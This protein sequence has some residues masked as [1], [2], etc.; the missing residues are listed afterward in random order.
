VDRPARP[1]R[2]AKIGLDRGDELI[3]R[4]ASGPAGPALTT[5]EAAAA[6]AA[7]RAGEPRALVLA[8]ARPDRRDDLPALI[9]AAGTADVAVTVECEAAGL[10]GATVMMLAAAGVAR[11]RVVHGGMRERVY[12]A[13]MRAPGSW[14]A[15]AAG[16]A[17]ALA[18]PVPVEL[19][20]PVVRWNQADVVPLV[21]WVG[22]LPGRL[23]RVLLAVPRGADLPVAAG[24][25]LLDHPAIA[26]VAGAAFAVAARARIAFGFDGGDAPWPCAAGDRLDRFATVWYD[27]LRRAASE[28]DRALVRIAA[29]A[30]CALATTCRGIEPAYRD[31]FG[32]EA[33]APVPAARAASW[34]LRPERG[35][36]EV[37][38]AQISP[39]ANLAAGAG[40]ALLRI[41]GHCQMACA[42]CFVDRG[43]GDLPLATITAELDRLAGQQ[44]DHV[45]LSGGEPTLHGEL[46]AILA[47]ARG[48]GF[49]TI[50]IQTNGVRCADRDYARSLVAAGL[51]KATVSLHSMDPATSDA[52]T[53]MPGAFPRTLAGLHQLAALGVETQLAHVISADNFRALPAFTRAMLDELAGPGRRLSV[54]FAVA[55]RIS[56]LVPAWVLPTFTEIRPFVTAALDLCDARGVGYGGLIGQG[57]YPPCVLGGDLRYHRGVLD[58]IYASADAERQFAKAPQCARCDFDRHCLGVRRDYLERHG[59]GELVPFA[60]DP[61]T[62][63]S[64]PAVATGLVPLR[65][66]AP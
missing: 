5:G 60:I 14:R 63:A 25:W 21:E 26:A 13:V 52:I 3:H 2:T 23:A 41:N 61:A 19:V 37:D 1:Q 50:E 10:D 15:A 22:E 66:R 31:R 64:L 57:G 48:L 47:H 40:R 39:F 32:V 17:A 43:V 51:I 7:A 30:D 56:D 4:F 16:L 49:A 20:I 29:C 42:F 8:V 9:A 33:L 62:A 18:G 12:E 34:R 11:L 36:G 55:Q 6:I 24:A 59:D 27:S 53:R 46:P 44:R 28:P 54:C 38:Y 65:R 35:G 45:V 58:K